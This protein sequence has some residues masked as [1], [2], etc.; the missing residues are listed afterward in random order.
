VRIVPCGSAV[1]A[2]VRYLMS[3]IDPNN[4]SAPGDDAGDAALAQRLTRHLS[5]ELDPQRGRSAEAFRLYALAEQRTRARADA[6]APKP[7]WRGGPWT[8]TLVGGAVAASI[9]LLVSAA[10][11]FWRTPTSTGGASAPT[12]VVSPSSP[13]SAPTNPPVVRSDRTTRTHFYDAGTVYDEQGRPMRRIRRV[14]VQELRWRN[15]AT[16]EQV[17]QV[18][19]SEEEFLYELKTY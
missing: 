3:E 4:P 10:V 7:V 17:D 1:T 15:E 6:P 11:P 14:N 12:R 19:P 5:A 13:V 2:M 9:A 16:G 18:V 8:F